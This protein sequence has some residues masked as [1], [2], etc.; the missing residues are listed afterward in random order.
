MSTSNKGNSNCGC[1]GPVGNQE[2][3]QRVVML[4]INK[5]RVV[6]RHKFSLD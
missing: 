3:V 5:R 2:C 4:E 6:A 1:T